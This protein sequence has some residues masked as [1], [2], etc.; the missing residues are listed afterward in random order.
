MTGTGKTKR[1]FALEQ[2]YNPW[3]RQSENHA[4]R[5]RAS[6][7]LRERTPF[8][9]QAMR[10]KSENNAKHFP[11]MYS[12]LSFLF[13]AV[14]RPSSFFVLSE[15]VG[16]ARCT[17]QSLAPITPTVKDPRYGGAVTPPTLQSLPPRNSVLLLFRVNFMRFYKLKRSCWQGI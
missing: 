9:E 17:N 5:S 16:T 6:E 7:W 10:Q 13:S 15:I 3:R 4:K 8:C 1:F 12:A 11:E 2:C 14:T